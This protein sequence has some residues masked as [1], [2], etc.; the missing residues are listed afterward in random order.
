MKLF[1]FVILVQQENVIIKNI[2]RYA[3]IDFEKE[4]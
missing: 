2:Y 3:S 4:T 1:T